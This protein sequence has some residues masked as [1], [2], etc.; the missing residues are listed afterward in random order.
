MHSTQSMVKTGMQRTGINQMGH[1]QLLYVPQPLKIGMFN[2]VEHQLGWYAYK[3][4][5]RIVY[6]FL[7]I[8]C[9]N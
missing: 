6:Y 2:K 1:A 4:V 8:Q 9:K 5:N 7:F 3:S